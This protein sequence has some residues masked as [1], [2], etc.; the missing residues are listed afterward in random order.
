M[1][2]TEFIIHKIEKEAHR[3]PMVTLRSTPLPGTDAHVVSFVELAVEVF[4]SNE[5]KPNSIFADFHQDVATFPLSKWCLE[6]F[7]GSKAFLDFTRDSTNRLSN[8]MQPQKL[9]TGGFVAFA[10]IEVDGASKL[11]IVMLHPQNGLSI[12][13][14]LEFSDVTH[15]EL[16]HMDK[17]AIISAPIN[18]QFGSKALTYAG[19]RKEMSQYFQ[20]FLGPDAFRNPSRDC[21]DLITTIENYARENAMQPTRLGEIQSQLREYVNLCVE[22]GVELKLDSI[23]AIVNPI[24]P[25]AFAVYASRNNVSAL[26]KPDGAVFK[27]WKLVRHKSADGLVLQFAGEI[28]GPPGTSQRLIFDEAELTLTINRVEPELVQKIKEVSRLS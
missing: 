20:Q 12:N 1:T 5:D 19:F 14:Q 7:S 16:K 21:R 4:K 22:E 11:L 10:K 9:S 28:V 24:A 2:I 17:A 23:S 13:D 27:R 8:C 15:L 18:G 26:I 3:D 25:N 6:Y